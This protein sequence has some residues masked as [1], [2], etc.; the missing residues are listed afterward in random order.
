MS[1]SLIEDKLKVLVD[2]GVSE[3][4]AAM[5]IVGGIL[6]QQTGGIELA[7]YWNDPGNFSIRDEFFLVANSHLAFIELIKQLDTI[8]LED[9]LGEFQ[10]AYLF[11]MKLNAQTIKSIDILLS[12]NCYADAFCI[13]RALQSRT[14]LLLLCVLAPELFDDWWSNPDAKRYR[15]GQVQKELA[16]LGINT[17]D[18]IYKLGCEI[19]H[20]HVIGHAGIGYFQEGWFKEISGVH[21]QI[22]AI[23]KFLLAAST[24]AFIQ[25]MLIGSKAGANIVGVKD[26]DQLYGH[27]FKTILAPN[28]I[29][30]YFTVF[31]AED[32]HWKK[33]GQNKFIG[34]GTY[35]FTHLK[36]LIHKFHGMS[37]NRH[38]LSERYHLDSSDASQ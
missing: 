15:E 31:L 6:F 14:N 4:Q 28:R 12:N 23:A 37:G 36:D 17:M 7:T 16:S 18:H 20:G 3:S 35:S 5:L 13:C 29:D 8:Y 22:Y 33:I 19:V 10:V 11:Q 25:A 9:W 27:F 38:R 2:Y 30:H 21:H 26:M 24:Y 34:G 1:D 32:R